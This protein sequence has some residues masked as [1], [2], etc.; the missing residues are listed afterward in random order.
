MQQ[1][2]NIALFRIFPGLLRSAYQ[3][4]ILAEDGKA[5]GGQ[6]PKDANLGIALPYNHVFEEPYSLKFIFLWTPGAFA[7]SVKSTTR[8]PPSSCPQ[9]QGREN[10][11]RYSC[12][13]GGIFSRSCGPAGSSP[14]PRHRDYYECRGALHLYSQQRHR[15]LPDDLSLLPGKGRQSRLDFNN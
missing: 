2:R 15:G 8:G 6:V 4:N 7:R 12:V 3:H 10:A 1:P 9:S 13:R 14:S 11:G 5:K